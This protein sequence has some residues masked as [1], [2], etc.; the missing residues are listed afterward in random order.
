LI[1][2]KCVL[3]PTL[4]HLYQTS[5]L[6]LGPFHIV[7]AVSLRLLYLF[8]YSKHI[9]HIRVL[10][11]LPFLY[12]PMLVLPL[13]FDPCPIILLHFFRFI[14]LIWG[15]NMIFGLLSLTNC[16]WE[17]NLVQPLWRTIWR[18]LKKTKCRSAICF[19]NTTP[20]DIPE[21]MQLRLLQRHLHA[22]I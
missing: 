11:F 10:G 13:T 17:C 21:G 19:S 14:I 15:E 9:N 2:C 12:Y 6:I 3:Q 5:S 20:R 8:L 18:L 22:H 16:W 4:V 1:P 7:A